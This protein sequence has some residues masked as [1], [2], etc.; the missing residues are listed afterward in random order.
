MQ[1]SARG[2]TF[3]DFLADIDYV[4]SVIGTDHVGIGTDLNG[5]G[6]E[7]VVP[8]HKEFALI[9]A[10]LLARG[11]TESDVAKIVGGNFMRVFREVTENSG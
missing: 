6:V 8:T 11:H 5:M 1:P 4:K 2:Q 9:P 10:G 3:D 7:T